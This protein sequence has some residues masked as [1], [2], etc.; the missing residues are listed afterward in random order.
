M[1]VHVSE[2]VYHNSSILVQTYVM[3]DIKKCFISYFFSWSACCFH[4]YEACHGSQVTCFAPK[5]S[6]RVSLAHKHIAVFPRGPWRV[7]GREENRVALT[8]LIIPSDCTHAPCTS[9]TRTSPLQKLLFCS[10]FFFFFALLT[11]FYL[12]EICV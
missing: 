12:S 7:T 2:P 4:T 3:F 1:S 9:E 11:L 6:C 8:S 5:Y 10:S